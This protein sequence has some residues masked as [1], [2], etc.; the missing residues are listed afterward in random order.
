MKKLLCVLLAV[1]MLASLS[2]PA[3]AAS[4]AP[5]YYV[6][7][8]DS[9]AEGYGVRNSNEACYGRIVADTN[10]Y[11]YQNFGRAAVDS[12]DLVNYLQEGSFY[13]RYYSI[14][15][16]VAA[17]DIISLSVGANDY[18]CYH[19]VYNLAFRAILGV[20]KA[21]LNAIADAF[22]DNLCMIINEIR[23][24]N[25]TAT[26]LVQKVY[27]IWYG[28]A[29]RAFD[30]AAS[31]CNAVIEKYDREHPGTILLCDITPAMN[32]HPENLADDCVHPNAKGNVA[33]AKIVL[34]QLYDLGLGAET[35]PVV[36]HPG[37]DYDLYAE[38]NPDNPLKGK[39]F[40]VMVKILTGNGVN[41]FRRTA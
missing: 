13:D 23:A 28:L 35:E 24:L 10:G 3:L 4:N 20:N 2:I 16:C 32:R 36:N 19:D 8:G 15:A 5:L 33:I 30:A 6:L 41:V 22:Y 27:S 38:E 37:I 40:T 9:I 34:Q 17:A 1:V 25:P 39:L 31:R 26:L 14:R 7:L 11:I 21:E 29:G 12:C 18:L